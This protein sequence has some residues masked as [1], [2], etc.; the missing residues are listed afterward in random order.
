MRM[1]RSLSRL[2]LLALLT[3]AF[4]SMGTFAYAQGATTQTLSGSVVDASG[5]VIPGADVAAKHSGTGTVTNAVSNSEG[6]FSIPSLPIGNYTVTVTLQGFKTVIIQS[7]V[8][9]AGAGA[10][11]KATMEVGG[12]TEQVTVSSSSE[13]VQTQ[14]SGVSTTENT[15]QI[16]KLPM[17]TRS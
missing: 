3:A 5:A 1:T 6:L 16:T 4:C 17:T 10:N 12:L 9:T 15:N 7:V 14:S 11:V 8:L 2:A 13:V